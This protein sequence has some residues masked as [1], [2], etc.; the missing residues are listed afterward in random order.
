MKC[1]ANIAFD[2]QRVLAVKIAKHGCANVDRGGQADSM[3]R[4]D[5]LMWTGEGRRTVCNAWMC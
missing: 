4:V 2:K 5:V 3:Q 1:D